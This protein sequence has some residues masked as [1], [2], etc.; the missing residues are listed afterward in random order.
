MVDLRVGLEEVAMGGMNVSPWV[1][2][3]NAFDEE[4]I[5][6]IAVSAFGGRF[7]EP[8][9]PRSFQIGMRARFGGGN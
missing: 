7:F 9:V 2:L 6:S 8:G 1:A 3:I 4:Y 5:A